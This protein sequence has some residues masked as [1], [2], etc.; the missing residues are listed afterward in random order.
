MEATAVDI[1][2]PSPFRQTCFIVFVT[3][4]FYLKQ[5]KQVIF[6]TLYKYI[7]GFFLPHNYYI[8][9]YKKKK[10]IIIFVAGILHL[11]NINFTTNGHNDEAYV[12]TDSAI[13]LET[14][15]Q[16]LGITGGSDALSD[17]LTSKVIHPPRADPIKVQLN[18]EE[19]ISSRD[20]FA[21]GMSVKSV[22]KN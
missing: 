12:T 20:A 4:F 19:A 3:F 17:A 11:G 13:S 22:T 2:N 9:N 21:K 5:P 16:L 15:S 8:L 1:S 7:F 18:D 10:K 14:A 6:L